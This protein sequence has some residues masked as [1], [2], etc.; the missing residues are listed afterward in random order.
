MNIFKKTGIAIMLATAVIGASDWCTDHGRTANLHW[1]AFYTIEGMF[2]GG[3]TELT[4]PYQMPNGAGVVKVFIAP[5]GSNQGWNGET[6]TSTGKSLRYVDFFL[7]FDYPWADAA[8]ASI[9][10]T[11]SNDKTISMLACETE[12]PDIWIISKVAVR[13]K[14]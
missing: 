10:N 9:L 2:S 5:E 6:T 12:N 8:W 7:P 14:W 3:Y 13:N 11:Y 4:V 1:T